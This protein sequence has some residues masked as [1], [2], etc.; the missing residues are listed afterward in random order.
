MTTAA[1]TN[2]NTLDALRQRIGAGRLTLLLPV[3]AVLMRFAFIML[4]NLIAW[5]I[6]QAQGHPTPW[7][8]A[9]LW[10]NVHISL[11]A[12]PLSIAF[13]VWALQREGITLKALFGK[14][15][16]GL[17]KEVLIGLV[18]TAA[19]TVTLFVGNIVG[20]LAVFGPSAFAAD[21]A[22]FSTDPSL[23]PPLG[24]YIWAL[25]VLPVTVGITEE[26]VYRGYAQPR[27]EALTGSR[28]A[29]LLIMAVGFG[30]QHMAISAMDWQSAVAR[31]IGT[32]LAG[33][34]FGLF[35]M[36]HRRLLPLIIGHWLV[37]ALFLG[38][39]PLISYLMFVQ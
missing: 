4:G 16:H 3:I 34:V 2:T 32:F 5:V 24:Y 11:V 10:S 8:Q 14:S 19:L 29:G 23:F 7:T 35:Y 30:I 1:N 12:D 36:K 39:L 21:S 6:F 28:W 18:V 37:N 17:G 15:E 33:I 25:V 22:T 31:F 20:A 27:L 38:L 13:L 26:L 9:L